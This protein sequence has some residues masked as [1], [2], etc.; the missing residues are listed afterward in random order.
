MLT[1]LFDPAGIT[2]RLRAQ[3]DCGLTVQAN[4]ERHL[5]A[6]G[7]AEVWF[8]G[9]RIDPLSDPRMDAPPS[10]HDECRVMLRPA[11]FD[12]VT[13]T[14]VA[15][16]ALT[17]VSYSLI[18]KPPAVGDIPKQSPN[19]S[20]TG[21]TNVARAYQAIP[22]LFGFSRAWPDL[23]QQAE[24]V[25]VDN[26]KVVTEWL[27]VSRGRGTVSA[28]QYA[29][30]PID[31]I[32]GAT[33]TIFPPAAT[34]N[35]YPELN[36]TTITDVREPFACEDVNGQEL[37]DVNAVASFEVVTVGYVDGTTT[38]FSLDLLDG[39]S[40]DPI[41][42]R[43]PSGTVRLSFEYEYDADV[44]GGSIA[45]FR[46][47]FDET[48]TVTASSSPSGGV[49]RLTFSAPAASVP[50][51][52]GDRV[53]GISL[54]LVARFYDDG[55]TTSAI[56]PFTLPQQGNEI[57]WNV[58][59]L[60]GLKGTVAFRA[61]WWKINEAG[62]EVGG[63]RETFDFSYS[64][65]SFDQ[66]F[67]TTTVIPAAGLGRYRITFLRLTPDLGNG[68]D[69]AKL[70]GLFAIRHFPT[71]T[72]P[73]V[74]VV[75]VVTTATPQATGFRERKF[76]LRWLRHVRTLTTTTLSESR[77][78]ARALLHLWC[79]AGQS[80]SEF[81][82]TT[83]AA[84][85]T[86][87]GETSALLRFDGGFDDADLSLG[88]RLQAIANTARCVIWRDGAVWTVTRD[89]GRPTPELQLDYRNLAR[90]GESAI[91]YA[92]HL[93]ASFDGVELEYVEELG[94]ARKAY[95]RL[96]ITTGVTVVGAS[97]NPKKIKLLGCRTQAQAD[98]RAQLEARKLLF[99]RV[100]V[101]DTA[102][103]EA[104]SLGIGST[105][106]WIDPADFAGDEL[107][108]GEVLAIN[109]STITTSE[110]LDF[111]GQPDGRMQFTGTD[112]AYLGAPVVVTP[113]GANSATL[114]SVPAG[115]YVRDGT[116]RQL[117]SRYVFGVGLTSA[118]LEAAGL[119]TVTDI[120]PGPD[121]T[122]SLSL[123]N[124]DGRIYGYDTPI[125]ATARG[126]AGARAASTSRR[127]SGIT[128]RIGVRGANTA[129]GTFVPVNL[130][131]VG[132]RGAN[133]AARPTDPNFADV[134]LLLHMD[135]T[136]GSTT[137]TD[138]SSS[139][140][141]VTV[142]G[143]TQIST[144]QN[145]FGKASGLFDGTGDYLRLADNDAW[146]FGSNNFTIECWVRASN[147]PGAGQNRGILGQ[148]LESSNRGWVIYIPPTTQ[149]VVAYF[150]Q[151]D[152]TFAAAMST[153]GGALTLNTWHH[154]A[155]VRDGSSFFLFIDGT[156][157]ASASSTVALQNST[158]VLDIGT[159]YSGS[160]TTN[161]F[162]NGHIDEVRITKGVARYIA[163]FTPP[164]S[165]FPDS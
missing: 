165:P 108:A 55:S 147:F 160:G 126:R 12:P 85:N 74:T 104:G 146:H 139:A 13:W 51:Q 151:N 93:P 20:L 42:A 47:V 95:S 53:G 113:A 110:P 84:I 145:R 130:A 117:G 76:N 33:Y 16:V 26:V 75:K 138:S 150:W 35:A 30:T 102:L 63:T 58:A 128:G 62:A 124:W 159:L 4:I 3:W 161:S 80:A 111:K 131:R 94:Q 148:S 31:D 141:T 149:D 115:L 97:S 100:S 39:A 19:N 72:L 68:A 28:I 136:N 48:V 125:L 99:Q 122:V 21:Q 78:F 18:P 157:R 43:V 119:Y 57:R 152:S 41:K 143:N 46:K 114:A 14:I 83:L 91:S 144:A 2:G 24:E 50:P 103:A 153:S 61:E 98:D 140:R 67:R 106:R 87:F 135:G 56:G 27:C 44:G 5:Q 52:P 49:A 132:V 133:T 116:T 86:E 107:Q 32:E 154:I 142:F 45:T 156:L 65:D 60:R 10:P 11:G 120:R 70:E 164:A 163:N 64:A 101:S 36:T 9:E 8:N 81:D 129:V 69:V 1:I 118:E 137:F 71:K 79:V 66:Q 22:D 90:S 7:D 112:G 89:Q 29:E 121:R 155:A 162:W 96:N 37:G 105:V 88:E 92:A 127:V 6:G 38:S 23:I 15:A 73:G 17:A 59:F 109:G 54:Y 82:T 25:Y 134:M 34:P 123:A 158:A 77:N 40:L